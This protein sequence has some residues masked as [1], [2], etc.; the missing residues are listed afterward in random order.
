MVLDCLPKHTHH[1]NDLTSKQL[2]QK[3]NVLSVRIQKLPSIKEV[4]CSDLG[5]RENIPEQQ[6]QKR[7]RGQ[8]QHS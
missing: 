6:Q 1:K 3:P 8:E 4:K 2:L 5:E 7:Y